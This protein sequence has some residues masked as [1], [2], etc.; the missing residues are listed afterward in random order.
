VDQ[1]QLSQGRFSI[2]DCGIIGAVPEKPTS[3]QIRREAETLRQTAIKLMEHAA[4]LIEKSAQLEHQVSLL[5]RDNSK[6][7]KKP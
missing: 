7:R 4:V 1:F 5:K 2:S 3:E 6:P